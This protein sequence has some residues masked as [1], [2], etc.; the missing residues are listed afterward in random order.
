PEAR[1]V[2]RTA[3]FT[4]SGSSTKVTTPSNG[5]ARSGAVPAQALAASP[6][7]SRAAPTHSSAGRRMTRPVAATAAP[8]HHGPA[9]LAH[10]RRV[11]ATASPMVHRSFMPAPRRTVGH[12]G[13]GLSATSGLGA[14]SI[15]GMR[16]HLDAAVGVP[17]GP[18]AYRR[19]L[20]TTGAFMALIP[21]GVALAVA[22]LVWRFY[23]CS[24]TSCVSSGAAGWLLAAMALPTSLV[25]GMPWEAGSVRY[26][27][28]GVTSALVW[29]GLGYAAAR[30]ATRSPVAD[31]RDW[32][33]EYA[34]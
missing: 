8:A 26:T 17:G 19:R 15:T 2:T 11:V 32:W 3:P 12:G 1:T 27:V 5:A 29:M 14:P 28:M 30:R 7:A 25:V 6:D 20:R 10:A 34:W 4:A 24:G 13:K 22:A 33:R 21:P 23:P 18:V 9:R 16:V 31:W